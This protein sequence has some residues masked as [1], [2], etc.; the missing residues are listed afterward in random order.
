MSFVQ[1]ISVL[2]SRGR[3]SAAWVGVYVGAE[4]VVAAL[5]SGRS[6]G[7]PEVRVAPVFD[8]ERA[9]HDLLEWQRR[10]YRHSATN[11][12][13]NSG[14]YQIL[15]LDAPPV[16]P[17]EQRGAVRWQIKDLID[18]PADEACIDCLAV[19]GAT[20]GAE[21]RRL[22]AVVAPKSKV[23]PWMQR[24]RQASLDLRA[25]DIPEM[26]FRNLSVLAAGDSPHAFVHVGLHS[27][28]LALIWQR[29]LCS[30]RKFDLSARMLENA[31]DEEHP[32][33]I[34]RLALEVQRTVDAFS[35]QFHGAD[36]STVWL[37]SL[38]Q[39][40]A[41]AAQLAPL[42]PQKVQVYHLAD[43]ITLQGSTPATDL[44][45]GI[46]VTLAIGAALRGDLTS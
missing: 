17:E 18:F 2:R 11:L 31:L 4:R 45:R 30:F 46:D 26:A 37:S 20:L 15:P 19:P 6:H 10:E 12:L 14:D 39:P 41:L 5:C 42:L 22:F 16:A 38:R 23:Q 8:G 3:S 29:E 35:R 9:A 40:D 21:S 27:T 24:Y 1:R 7:R 25:I 34:E 44:E 13:L 32:L 43:H 28:R 36:L 33:I